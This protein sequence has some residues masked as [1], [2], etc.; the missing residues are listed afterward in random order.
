MLCLCVC[1]K[2]PSVTV[3]CMLYSVAFCEQIIFGKAT[4]THT[5]IDFCQIIFGNADK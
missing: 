4:Q 3:L 1:N 2:V 5:Y